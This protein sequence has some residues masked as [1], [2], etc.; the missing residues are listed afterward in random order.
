MAIPLKLLFLLPAPAM[1][2]VPLG[3]HPAPAGY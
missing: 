2:H 1:M 3:V